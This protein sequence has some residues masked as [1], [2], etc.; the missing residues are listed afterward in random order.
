MIISNQDLLVPFYNN[1]TL[2]KNF[3]ISDKDY[4][5]PIQDMITNEIF[6]KYWRWMQSL[7][8][9]KW[10]HRWDCDNFADAFKLFSCGYYEQVI[11]STANGIGIGVINYMANQRAE[12]G[13]KG[14]HAINIIYAQD[15]KN[16]EGS[17]NF[18]LLFL[19]PQNGKFYNL[20]QEEFNSIW[21]VYI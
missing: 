19:E 21:T 5:C 20:T 3:V 8:W 16:D 18:K 6:P 15:E 2:P 1:K 13:V 14:G 4:F 7:R 17:D 11:E 12:D 10:M 9:S